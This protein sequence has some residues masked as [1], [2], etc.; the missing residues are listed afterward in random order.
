MKRRYRP[1]H[2]GL[3]ITVENHLRAIGRAPQ[4]AYEVDSLIAIKR[5]VQAGHVCTV[6]PLG[7]VAQDVELGRLTMVPFADSALHRT[8]LI[9]WSNERPITPQTKAVLQIIRSETAAL[10]RGGRWG[11][12]YFGTSAS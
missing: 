11:S 10:V 7:N 1:R 3:R 12:R 4:I 2:N 5:L 6:M 8:L 9:A